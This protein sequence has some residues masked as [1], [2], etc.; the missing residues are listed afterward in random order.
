MSRPFIT[1]HQS[2]ESHRSHRH[3]MADKV[4]MSDDGRQANRTRTKKNNE[5]AW[6]LKVGEAVG[7]SDVTY[8]YVFTVQ[9]L[10]LKNALRLNVFMWF[11]CGW[12]LFYEAFHLFLKSTLVAS[13]SIQRLSWLAFHEH[14]RHVSFDTLPLVALCLSVCATLKWLFYVEQRYHLFSSADFLHSLEKILL[15][16]A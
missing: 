1:T 8:T 2:W 3:S 16:T 10:N 6:E 11:F 5:L 12:K 7:V 15:Y 14:K 9:H 4:I 13:S